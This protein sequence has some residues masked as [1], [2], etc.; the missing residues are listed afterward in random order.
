MIP[1][2]QPYYKYFFKTI[3]LNVL[4]VAVDVL[5]RRYASSQRGTWAPAAMRS[6]CAGVS[7][8]RR[9][10]STVPSERRDSSSRFLPPGGSAG[11]ASV[12]PTR[13][14]RGGSDHVSTQLEAGGDHYAHRSAD[15]S[16]DGCL[17]DENAVLEPEST[18]NQFCQT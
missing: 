9:A 11:G 13:G 18:R 10:R 7:V 17:P 15:R 3:S 6:A 12:A 4:L 2:F 14:G 5:V 1:F 8:S 16:V